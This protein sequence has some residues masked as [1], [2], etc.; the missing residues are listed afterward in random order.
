MSKIIAFGDCMLHNT[1]YGRVS[2]NVLGYFVSKGHEVYQ[3]AWNYSLP[4]NK[5]PIYKDGKE[6]VGQ[7]TLVPVHTNDQFATLTLIHYL[8]GFK[9]DFI[10]NSNDYFTIK[11]FFEQKNS[12]THK[13]KV[14]NYGIIDGPEC[15]KVYKDIIDQVDYPVS[16]SKYGYNQLMTY[17]GKG[18]YIP[19]GVDTA[20]YKPLPNKDQIKASL[21][22][23]D[24][25]VFG[26]VNRNIWRKMYPLLFRAYANIKDKMKDSCLFLLCDP[27]DAAGHALVYWMKHYGLTYSQEVNKP[28]DVMFHPAYMNLLLNL[29]DE[30]LCMA[31]NAFDVYVS[32]SMSEGFGLPT[33]ES[34]ACGIPSIMPDNTA[35]T[36]LVKGHGWLYQTVKNKNG[37]P[38]IM[39]ANI[40][41]LGWVTY[42]YEMPDVDALEECMLEAY[43][44]PGK[45]AEYGLKS[46]NFATQYDWNI[47]LK[48]WDNIL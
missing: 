27:N 47:V 31:Y 28:A 22:L 16:P 11:N 37:S 32:T 42:G 38:V 15:A 17:T 1:G 12:W 26:V 33:I 8:N 36:E 29:S 46:Y 7:V 10:Y 9:P 5:I 13:A 45:V 14:I 2:R 24:K 25:F 30:E 6:L 48:G 40:P 43:N 19:H 21:G 35:N 34:Q 3:I 44:S 4:P 20:T 18:F 23:K 41:S 39:P